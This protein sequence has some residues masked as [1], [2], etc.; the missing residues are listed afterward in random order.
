MGSPIAGEKDKR[1][2]RREAGDRES[3]R[4]AQLKGGPRASAFLLLLS[5]VWCTMEDTHA[6]SRT[7]A[8]KM[9]RVDG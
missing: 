9:S 3:D 2:Q 5:P 7:A 8:G 1:Q 6:L 4:D